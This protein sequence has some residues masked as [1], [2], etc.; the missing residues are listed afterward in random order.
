MYVLIVVD[1]G[2]GYGNVEMCAAMHEM[3][4]FCLLHERGTILTGAARIVLFVGLVWFVVS[5]FPFF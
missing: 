3:F 4:F 2:G 5:M 1:G